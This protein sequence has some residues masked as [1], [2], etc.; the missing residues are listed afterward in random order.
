MSD[1]SHNKS[2]L[3]RNDVND[4]RPKFQVSVLNCFPKFFENV[5]KGQLMSFIENPLSVFL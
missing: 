4:F 1:N 3:D 2:S 5:I